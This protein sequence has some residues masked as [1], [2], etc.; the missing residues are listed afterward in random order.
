[1][2]TKQIISTLI[3]AYISWLSYT[4]YE[5]SKSVA[6]IEAQINMTVNPLLHS[7]SGGE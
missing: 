7:L 5:T 1:M 3:V 2:Q 4:V 6:V